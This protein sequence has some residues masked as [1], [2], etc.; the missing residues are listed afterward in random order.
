MTAAFIVLEAR[1]EVIDMSMERERP[2]VH[3]H[4]HRWPIEFNFLFSKPSAAN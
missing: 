3:L 1:Q 2:E 4:Q